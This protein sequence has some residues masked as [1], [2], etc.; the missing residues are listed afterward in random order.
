VFRVG[1]QHRLWFCLDHLNRVKMAA[2]QFYLQSGKQKSRVGGG[3]QSCCFGQK[4]PGEKG[5]VRMC[6]VIIQQPVPLLPKFR[7]KTS[8]IFTQ[9]PWNVTAV[10]GIDCLLFTVN[11]PLDAK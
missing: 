3:W 1:V 5:S 10:S 9:S 4:F 7:T 6:V 11:I 8:H 2:F